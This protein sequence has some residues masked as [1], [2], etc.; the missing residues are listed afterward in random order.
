MSRDYSSQLRN[1]QNGSSFSPRQI[2]NQNEAAE[3][4]QEEKCKAVR[5][6]KIG[7]KVKKP[8]YDGL[9][10]WEYDDKM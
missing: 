5:M 8:F 2:D 4:R 3:K 6:P 1:E 10:P 9:A 7:S